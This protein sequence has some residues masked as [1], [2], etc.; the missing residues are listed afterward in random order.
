[1]PIIVAMAF[2]LSSCVTVTPIETSDAD[3]HR[4]QLSTKK[5]SL[6]TIGHR[7]GISCHNSGCLAALGVSAL[8]TVSTAVISGSIVLIGNSVHWLEKQGKC[9]DGLLSFSVEEHNSPLLQQQGELVD[10]VEDEN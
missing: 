1:M 7:S 8:Y 10:L 5:L 4:C 3:N 9:D 6:K 2:L